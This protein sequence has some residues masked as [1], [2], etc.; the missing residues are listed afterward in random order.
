[1]YG[2]YIAERVTGYPWRFYYNWASDIFDGEL[3]DFRHGPRGFLESMGWDPDEWLPKV[4]PDDVNYTREDAEELAGILK[5]YFEKYAEKKADPEEAT[6]ATM[7]ENEVEDFI[8][9]TIAGRIRSA[10]SA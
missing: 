2:E 7:E 9:N 10:A 6:V 3:E 4:K 5:K 1:M 8:A